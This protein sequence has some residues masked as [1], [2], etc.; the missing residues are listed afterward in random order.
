MLFRT[1]LA[2]ERLEIQLDAELELPWVKSG[3]GGA[4]VFS[5]LL[6]S[7]SVDGSIE[8]IRRR[9]V[10]AIEKVEALCDQLNIEPLIKADPPRKTC[11][12]RHIG[13]RDT[14]ITA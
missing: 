11:V 7:V 3:C 12:E 10:K 6:L 14:H 4:I 8:R 13:M 5:A 9:F 1:A 2:R